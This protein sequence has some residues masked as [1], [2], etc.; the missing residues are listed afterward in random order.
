MSKRT[1]KRKPKK[2]VPPTVASTSGT[3][4]AFTQGRD[5]EIIENIENF[6][7]LNKE[8]SISSGFESLQIGTSS[9]LFKIWIKYGDTR[10]VKIVFDGEDVNDLIEAIKEELSPDLDDVPLNRINLRRH[11][12]EDVKSAIEEFSQQNRVETIQ[13]SNLSEGKAKNTLDHLGLIPMNELEL[14]NANVILTGGADISI[15]ANGNPGVWIKTKKRKENFKMEGKK[16]LTT[17][18]IEER[19]IALAIIKQFILKEGVGFDD[20]MAD[21]IDDMTEKELY[22]MSMRKK[23]ITKSIVKRDEQSII[24]Q[25]ITLM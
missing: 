1:Y 15:E 4:G 5:A 8:Q 9:S 21:L 23:L 18:E 24:D 14:Q 3:S 12:V 20:R 11:D 2:D 25:F 7:L 13:L 6:P 22:S 17:S 19:N 10:P 16:Y